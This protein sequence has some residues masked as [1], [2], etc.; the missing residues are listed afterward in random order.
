MYVSS[1]VYSKDAAVFTNVMLQRTNCVR[2]LVLCEY[3]WACGC[4]TL[5]QAGKQV[6]DNLLEVP[7]DCRV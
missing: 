4:Y 2:L 5:M 1:T 3:A 7:W 6:M